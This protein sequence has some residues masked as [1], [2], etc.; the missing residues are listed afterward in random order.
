MQNLVASQ[1]DGLGGQVRS[2]R[3]GGGGGGGLRQ[4][5]EAVDAASE[6]GG[7]SDEE[8][9]ERGAESEQG[10]GNGEGKE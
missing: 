2:S 1:R 10:H 6:R 3:R 8:R 7:A 9:A 5:M 4:N